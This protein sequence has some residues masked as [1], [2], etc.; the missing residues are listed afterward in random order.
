MIMRAIII[1]TFI[2]LSLTSRAQHKTLD[3]FEYTTALVELVDHH[4][5]GCHYYTVYYTFKILK[6]LSGPPN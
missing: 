1:L 2:N 4:D 5:T 3:S 6:Q